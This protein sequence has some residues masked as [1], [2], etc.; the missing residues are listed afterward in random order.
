M[1]KL[2]KLTFTLRLST[3]YGHLYTTLSLYVCPSML[4][5]WSKLITVAELLVKSL[6]LL[7]V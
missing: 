3:L 4:F 1:Y 6:H 5:C 7:V 2:I